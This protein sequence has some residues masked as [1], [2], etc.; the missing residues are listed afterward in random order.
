MDVW[1]LEKEVVAAAVGG[2][3]VSALIAARVKELATMMLTEQT[4]W[5]TTANRLGTRDASSLMFAPVAKEAVEEMGISGEASTVKVGPATHQPAAGMAAAVVADLEARARGRARGRVVVAVLL[6]PHP[7]PEH[8]A[9]RAARAGA[10]PLP[11]LGRGLL[12][13]AVVVHGGWE[14]ALGGTRDAVEGS[15][16]GPR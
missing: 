2:S 4:V 1:A 11:P 16:G 5:D 3:E 15:V 7:P 12:L 13:V 14:A 9:A 10:A 8:G 6:L